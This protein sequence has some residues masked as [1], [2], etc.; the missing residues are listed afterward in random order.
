MASRTPQDYCASWTDDDAPLATTTHRD[1][2]DLSRKSAARLPRLA[3]KALQRWFAAHSSHPYPTE[4]EKKMLH[5]Q[6]NLSARQISNWFANARRRRPASPIDKPGMPCAGSMSVPNLA[7]TAKW[8]HMN[9]M[10]RWRNSPPDQEPAPLDAIAA[11]VRDSHDFE[12]MGPPM[13]PDRFKDPG[14]PR[15]YSDMS[16]ESTSSVGTSQSS[17]STGS[18]YSFVSGGSISN[19]GHSW[20]LSRRRRRRPLK[21][22]PRPS[23]NPQ[24]DCNARR[25]QCTFCTDT[26]KSKYDWTRHESTLHLLLEKWVCCAQGPISFDQFPR[27]AFCESPNPTTSHLQSHN[28]DECAAK[29]PALRIFGRKDHL[30]QHLRLVHGV[31]RMTDSMA[32][33]KSKITSVNCR[34]G[35]CEERFVRWSDRND[36][37]AEH[38][39]EGASMKEWKGCRGLDPEIALLVENAMPPYLIG[40]ERNEFEPFSASRNVDRVTGSDPC[41]RRP[42]T[43]FESLTTRLGDYVLRAMRDNVVVT[44]ETVRRQARIIMF[45]DSDAW[46]QTP[47]DNA[48]WLRLFKEGVRLQSATIPPSTQFDQSTRLPSQPARVLQEPALGVADPLIPGPLDCA[49]PLAEAS[50]PFRGADNSNDWFSAYEVNEELGFTN[51]PLGWQ[52]PE[53][54]A[55]FSQMFPMN[56]CTGNTSNCSPSVFWPGIQPS[57][58]L[59][60]L[61]PTSTHPIDPGTQD[62]PLSN[63]GARGSGLSKCT[64]LDG[65]AFPS[66]L[67]RSEKPKRST[68]V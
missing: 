23:M 34:C 66:D 56:L 45:G 35:F 12:D 52:T 19:L 47:A 36:H 49:F 5:E 20:H 46:N 59:G 9:P 48:E 41:V 1:G 14:G 27:C 37:I 4:Q 22:I 53:C 38:F 55:E 18:A 28:Y 44:D 3:T 17:H 42:P 25:F 16:F 13:R 33:W 57:D 15:A 60:V 67:N 65:L 31:E 40:S 24:N 10:D 62:P 7:S 43:S 29:P 30:R 61:I 58:T 50:P 26:F 6:T 54:L 32:A 63:T 21:Q 11:A 2:I 8:Q 64:G 51:L 68:H 39:R